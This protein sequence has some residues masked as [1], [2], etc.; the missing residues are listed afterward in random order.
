VLPAPVAEGSPSPL[1]PPPAPPPRARRWPAVLA[2]VIALLGLALLA[3]GQYALDE[4]LQER[5]E[6]DAALQFMRSSW[7]PRQ[8][9]GIAGLALGALLAAL[10]LRR[11]AAPYDAS[12][13]RPRG[14]PHLSRRRLGWTLIAASLAAN[15]A[16]CYHVLTFV[17]AGPGR[18]P[19]TVAFWLMYVRP[20]A[21]ALVL[22]LGASGCALL[23]YRHA[24]PRLP[25]DVWDAL[26]ILATMALYVGFTAPFLEDARWSVVGDEY[27]FLSVAYELASGRPFDP[28]WQAGVYGVFPLVSSFIQAL[29]MRLFGFDIFGWKMGCVVMGA[30]VVPPTYLAARWAFDRSVAC[31]AAG[32]IATSHYLWA[33][34]HTGHNNI[35]GIFPIAMTSLLVLVAL[36]RPSPLAWWLAGAAAGSSFYFFTAARVSGLLLG[37]AM[38][39]R[40]PRKLFG[41]LAP[42]LLGCLTVLA[43]FVARNQTDT[44]TK[45]LQ[46]SAT[47]KASAG[48]A[49]WEALGLTG[50]SALAFHW[51]TAHGLYISLGL[52]D[53]I[54][55]A[56]SAL[57]IGLALMR[58]GDWRRRTLIAWYLVVLLITGGLARHSDISVPRLL[59]AMPTLAILIGDAVSA[60]IRLLGD[61]LGERSRRALAVAVPLLLTATL[62][63]ANAHRFFVVTPG[64]NPLPPES[65]WLAGAYHP[66]CRAAGTVPVVV[67]HGRGG[68]LWFAVTSYDPQRYIPLLV[69]AAEFAR[70]PAYLDWPCIVL[71]GSR[72]PATERIVATVK[73]KNPSV[74]TLVIPDGTGTRDAVVLLQANVPDPVMATL[75]VAPGG[76]LIAVQR[77]DP[78]RFG[79]PGAIHEAVGLA[80]GPGGRMF[81]VDRPGQR[82][83]EFAA[84][85]SFVANWGGPGSLVAPAAAAADERGLLVVDA[86][87]RRV[88]EFD[89]DR[90]RLRALDWSA[91]GLGLPRAIA[92]AADG[93]VL[94]ADEGQAAL[95]V[96]DRDLRPTGKLLEIATERDRAQPFRPTDV[97]VGPDGSVV[98][99]DGTTVGR[100]RRYDRQGA[101]AASFDVRV[102]EGRVAVAPDGSLWVGGPGGEGLRHLGPDG[103]RL[104][105]YRA[106]QFVGGTGEGGVTG[107][108][109]DERGLIRV[110]WR[111]PGVVSYRVQG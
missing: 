103:E 14:L 20:I 42:A 30:L 92:I 108:T 32:V 6:K 62:A 81:A 24:G 38:L 59:M 63:G 69:D 9:P 46:E 45:M 67:G 50:L 34:G 17:E 1:P 105:E 79:A 55:A 65:L 94:V 43:P 68:P 11:W 75:P 23:A 21:Y 104:G 72:E 87:G 4:R 48:Q 49:L 47:T 16:L 76:L 53:P 74:R 101:L 18:D 60:L 5:F 33:Y 25:F 110:A 86:E 78:R 73:R 29:T 15:A 56:L 83:A 111:Y 102:R 44:I 13:D 109:A 85:G 95:H 91:L 98:A 19:A 54:S 77:T 100:V 97:A 99:Y 89:R 70:A 31:V 80:A 106:N 3:A 51:S 37:L 66:E 10:G 8:A 52:L 90:R 27:A 41:G 71:I 61:G 22:A 58:F 96:F 26:W 12:R 35:D 7:A 2:F 57:G 93:R 40:G 88:V 28:F 39:A 36:M 84:D 64:R 107:L 82:V